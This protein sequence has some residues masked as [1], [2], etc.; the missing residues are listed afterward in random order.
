MMSVACRGW[1]QATVAW[2][3]T[4]AGRR[5]HIKQKRTFQRAVYDGYVCL[6]A[7]SMATDPALLAP[8]RAA[9]RRRYTRSR[10]RPYNLV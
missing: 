8:T 4:E 6:P 9:G 3:E 1:W 2:P 7:L 5:P 10:N